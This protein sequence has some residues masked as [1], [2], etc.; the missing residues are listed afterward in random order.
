MHSSLRDRDIVV[1]HYATLVRQYLPYSQAH[2]LL[3]IDGFRDRSGKF[4]A[5]AG[6]IIDFDNGSCW[7]SS[8]IGDFKA[9]VDPGL[10]EFLQH[11]TGL[12][13]EHSET[14]GD[15]RTQPR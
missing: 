1:G 2:R 8:D 10:A 6:M 3:L 13:V 5:H 14:E 7:S 11:K 9:K 12:R 4:T 15:F